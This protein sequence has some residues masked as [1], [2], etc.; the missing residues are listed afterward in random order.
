[1]G[2]KSAIAAVK[3]T[4]PSAQIV[5]L[6]PCPAVLPVSANLS[7]VDSQLADVSANQHLNYVSCVREAWITSDNYAQVIDTSKSD[8][9]STAGH[10]YLATK[11]EIAM[12]RVIVTKS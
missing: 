3:D 7:S 1:M 11:V 6:G 2:A 9:P 10:A 8:H 4:W 5:V 12:K